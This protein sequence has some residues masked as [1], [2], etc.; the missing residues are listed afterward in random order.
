MVGDLEQPKFRRLA[1]NRLEA[2]TDASP[3]VAGGCL[4]LR[5]ATDLYCVEPEPREAAAAAGS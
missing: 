5:T 3:A 2:R 4:L 1:E